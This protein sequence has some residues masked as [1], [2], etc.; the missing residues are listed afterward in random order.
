MVS[1]GPEVSE[2]YP[3][4][5]WL[6]AVRH[7]ERAVKDLKGEKIKIHTISDGFVVFEDPSGAMGSNALLIYYGK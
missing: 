2:D 1:A 5:P 4:Y 3:I 6:D 7:A